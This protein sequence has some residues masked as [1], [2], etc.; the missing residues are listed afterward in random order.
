MMENALAP[1]LKTTAPTCVT[2]EREILVVF[3]RQKVLISV[4]PFG[5]LFGVHLAA[6][7]QVPLVGSS[8]QVALPAWTEELIRQMNPERSALESAARRSRR[9]FVIARRHTRRFRS[10]Q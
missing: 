9:W 6:S 5:M 3:E 1:G 2:A 4:A 7:F 8:F 10:G